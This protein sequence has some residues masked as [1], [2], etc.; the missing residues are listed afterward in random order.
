M[1]LLSAKAVPVYFAMLGYAV[2][3]LVV[4]AALLELSSYAAWSVYRRVH[5][6]FPELRTTSPV[7]AGQ[8]WAPEF[9]KEEAA[10]QYSRKVYVPFR[11]W[12]PTSWH[13]QYVNNDEAEGGVWRRTIN[14][15]NGACGAGHPLALWVFGGSTV[16]GTGV[17]D[18]GTLPSYLSRDLNADGRDCVVVTN[19][20][21]EGYVSNQELLWLL[22]R[23]KTGQRPDIVVFYDG[24]NDASAA[25]P[26]LGAPTAHFYYGMIKGQIEGSL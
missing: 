22:E 18:W 3:T 7:Y 14:P 17:P 9:L 5:P 8:P 20:G 2:V 19:F 15:A 4:I 10:R 13:A 21:V 12:A 25:G 6:V 24:V 26:W 1:R 23:L 16:Y 11:L